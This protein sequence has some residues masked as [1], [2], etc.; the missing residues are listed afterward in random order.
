MA[1]SQQSNIMPLPVTVLSGLP[2]AGKT[3]LLAQLL[4][5]Q[6]GQRMAVI[7]S[8]AV[9]PVA[10]PPTGSAELH[11]HTREKVIYLATEDSR[12]ALRADLLP[13]AGRLARAQLADALLIENPGWAPLQPV[14]NTFSLSRPAW[15]LDLPERT[16]LHGLVT[17]VDA[18]RFWLDLHS[19][20]DL[21]TPNEEAAETEAAAPP[22]PPRA[23][24]NVLL[25]QIEFA[26]VLVVSKKELATPEAVSQLRT[27]LR[28]FNPQAR[29][30]ETSL[31]QL[32]PAELLGAASPSPVAVPAAHGISSWQFND[33]RPFHP[34]RLWHLVHERWPAAL[35]RSKGLFWLA[36]RPEE[37]LSWH[38]T[39]PTHQAEAVGTWW[40]A[41]PNRH[42]DPGYQRDARALRAR[43]HPQFQDR[44]NTLSF[45]GLNLDEARW[46]A[47]LTA[48][49]CTPLEI[50]RWR[51]GAIFPDPWPHA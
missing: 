44:L 26:N 28:H 50:S 20:D 14:V 27:L 43:W 35:L 41:V 46:R 11:L 30:V 42:L 22:H 9:A 29:L 17:V 45:T 25:E 13:E 5:R 39:G 48:C 3:T 37:V 23:R 18:S 8:E 21:P 15:G 2:G 34:E 6:A 12:V 47:D 38:Q 40:A 32:P 7:S 4:H 51:R 31:G 19:T 36:S 33:E 10:A 24:A 1:T 16:Q 49:L